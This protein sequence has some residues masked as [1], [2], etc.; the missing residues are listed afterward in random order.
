MTSTLEAERTLGEEVE[1]AGVIVGVAGSVVLCASVVW[2]GHDWR[3]RSASRR[4]SSHAHHSSP[5]C[6]PHLQHQSELQRYEG[7]MFR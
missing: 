3:R 2:E 4:F 6:L 5:L 7:M 1:V